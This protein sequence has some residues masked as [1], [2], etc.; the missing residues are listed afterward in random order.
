MTKL[1]EKG[2]A[3]R[4]GIMAIH[5]EACYRDYA[6]AYLPHTERITDK[7]LL[8]PLYPRLS[9]KEQEFIIHAL[10]EILM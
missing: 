9:D 8:L 6:A 2:I 5:R 4:R 1:L 3:T 7:T 10:K